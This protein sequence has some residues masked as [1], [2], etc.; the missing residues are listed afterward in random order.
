LKGES[1]AGRTFGIEHVVDF[2]V[3]AVAHNAA[4]QLD[5]RADD[6]RER[7]IF[8]IA[9]PCRFRQ[10]VWQRS[11]QVRDGYGEPLAHVRDCAG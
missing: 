8:G 6:V 7:R 11:E 9:H 5:D 3:H 1:E 10:R 2:A 4:A